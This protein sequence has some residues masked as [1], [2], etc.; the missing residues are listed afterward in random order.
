MKK[1]SYDVFVWDH[2]GVVTTIVKVVSDEKEA[3]DLVKKLDDLGID[4]CYGIV[5]DRIVNGRCVY[6][7]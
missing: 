3:S 5:P 4:A 7:T 2:I 6:E 1:R